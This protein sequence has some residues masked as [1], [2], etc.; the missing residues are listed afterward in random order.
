MGTASWHGLVKH[1][2]HFTTLPVTGQAKNMSCTNSWQ[3]AKIR[4]WY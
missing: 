4:V 2:G 1:R 3:V